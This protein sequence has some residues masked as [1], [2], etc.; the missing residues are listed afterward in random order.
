MTRGQ[1]AKIRERNK[2]QDELRIARQKADLEFLLKHEQFHRYIKRIVE[3]GGIMQKSFTGN[4]TTF[5]NLGSQEFAK[6]IWATIAEV[7]REAAVKLLLPSI[8][9]EE[10]KP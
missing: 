6:Q 7:D 4:S 3:A 9:D 8:D 1:E 2:A 10:R 5:Y